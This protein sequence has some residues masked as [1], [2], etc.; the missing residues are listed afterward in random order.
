VKRRS[1]YLTGRL[2]YPLGTLFQ[3]TAI[4]DIAWNRYTGSD[5]H[6]A[7][8]AQNAADGTN[9]RSCSLQSRSDHRN[10]ADGVQ[11][12]GVLGHSP[13]SYAHRTD[14]EPWGLFDNPA[15]QFTSA[16]FDPGQDTY[17]PGASWRSRSGPPLQKL[18][19]EAD[20]LTARIWIASASTSSA[21]S[22]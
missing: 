12:E 10:P 16:T 13:G 9:S 4:A 6:E 2:G 1:Q 3:F 22:G 19:V 8:A 21:K 18:K 15:G 11:Q 17:P 20:Y 7:L 14:W 5:A